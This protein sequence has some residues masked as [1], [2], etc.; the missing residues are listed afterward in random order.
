MGVCSVQP[1]DPVDRLHCC[2]WYVQIS[3]CLFQVP[4]CERT[5][6]NTKY[7]TLEPRKFILVPKTSLHVVE[8]LEFDTVL[9]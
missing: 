2:Y 6:R 5:Y 3:S 9:V 1:F 7:Q 8:N 4:V